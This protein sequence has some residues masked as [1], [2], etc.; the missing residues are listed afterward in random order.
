MDE[1]LRERLRNA[2]DAGLTRSQLQELVG[3]LVKQIVVY[4]EEQDGAKASLRVVVEYNFPL[5]P[6]NGAQNVA[7]TDTGTG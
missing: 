7:G 4:T 3:L 6:L 5:S 1:D 2:L